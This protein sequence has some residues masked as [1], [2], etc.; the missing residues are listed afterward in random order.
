[1]KQGVHWSA[2]IFSRLASTILWWG[3]QI[4][5]RSPRRYDKIVDNVYALLPEASAAKKKNRS[6]IE[7]IISLIKELN[8]IL[9]PSLEASAGIQNYLQHKQYLKRQ[10][11][12]SQ[13]RSQ[14]YQQKIGQTLLSNLEER[15]VKITQSLQRN[16]IV[17]SDIRLPSLENLI[18]YPVSLELFDD[19]KKFRSLARIDRDWI[20]FNEKAFLDFQDKL[21]KIKYLGTSEEL[22]YLESIIWGTIAEQIL[23]V[24]WLEASQSMA[25]DEVYRLQQEIHRQ[26]NASLKD[27]RLWQIWPLSQKLN[28]G[29]VTAM[30]QEG[31]LAEYVKEIVLSGYAPMYEVGEINLNVFGHREDTPEKMNRLVRLLRENGNN[32]IVSLKIAIEING[33]MTETTKANISRITLKHPITQQEKIANKI[34]IDLSNLL[35]FGAIISLIETLQKIQKQID[36][37]IE[38]GM[39]SNLL[40]ILQV[41]REWIGNAIVPPPHVEAAIAQA[42]EH[43]WS[44]HILVGEELYYSSDIW[45][46]AYIDKEGK[47]V[48]VTSSV[49]DRAVKFTRKE[50]DK[51]GLSQGK[52]WLKV[53]QTYRA[54]YRI[55]RVTRFNESKSLPKLIQALQEA[56]IDAINAQLL[57]TSY[58]DGKNI[59]GILGGFVIRTIAQIL[60]LPIFPTMHHTVNTTDLAEAG[61]ATNL[62][63]WLKITI[64]SEAIEASFQHKQ[65]YPVLLLKYYRDVYQKYYGIEAEKNIH[66]F[67]DLLGGQDQQKRKLEPNEFTV[68]K[69]HWVGSVGK[70]ET[71][72]VIESAKPSFMA[73]AIDLPLNILSLGLW[74]QKFKPKPKKIV[75]LEGYKQQLIHIRTAQ[76][77]AY[78]AKKIKHTD[79]NKYSN[80]QVFGLI[81]GGDNPN[82]VGFTEQLLADL[83]K[84]KD[85]LYGTPYLR[86]LIAPEE[87]LVVLQEEVNKEIIRSQNNGFRQISSLVKTS[88]HS[89]I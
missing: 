50:L 59:T 19:S 26:V 49:E 5:L 58:M 84:Q 35:K 3:V 74:S 10:N 30:A 51:K 73:R 12:R 75:R 57:L 77:T 66:G 22:T 43:Q 37:S 4:Y 38:S 44:F 80:F 68:N 36:N 13:Q 23:K 40:T 89:R 52:L 25:E 82:A 81:A 39:Y 33:N 2:W 63:D 24:H 55:Y 72:K 71:R 8:L 28:I 46:G 20:I 15:V 54:E 88:N 17:L 34:V 45:G 78:L 18:L 7:S 47:T 87:V 61:K 6:K 32:P 83:G 70:W 65:I 60:N 29:I 64:G 48:K 67:F 56:K 86:S 41:D 62:I 1:M 69:T 79:L 9:S 27:A 76:K 11:R 16:S 21:E 14:E 53:G 85:G 31:G 42:K